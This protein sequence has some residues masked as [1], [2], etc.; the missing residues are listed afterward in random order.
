MEL[1]ATRGAIDPSALLSVPERRRR[2]PLSSGVANPTR[3]GSRETRAR[4]AHTPDGGSRVDE[5]VHARARGGSPVRLAPR[6]RHLHATSGDREVARSRLGPWRGA[7][8]RARATRTAPR[9]RILC[10]GPRD[11]ERGAFGRPLTSVRAPY[12]R[13]LPRRLDSRRRASL[14]WPGWRVPVVTYAARCDISHSCALKG[15]AETRR[16]AQAHACVGRRSVVSRARWFFKD[17]PPRPSKRKLKG[18]APFARR[19]RRRRSA[20]THCAVAPVKGAAVRACS[21][22]RPG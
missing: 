17:F 3:G 4:F 11:Q 14:W 22:A 10:V 2:V 9:A 16:H 12:A 8:R 20:Q 19:D 15:R 6:P 18:D 13:R 1:T 5:R 7:G 21:D